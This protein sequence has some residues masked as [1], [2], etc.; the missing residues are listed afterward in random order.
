M[1]SNQIKVKQNGP[2]WTTKRTLV[3]LLLEFKLITCQYEKLY[4]HIRASKL[5]YKLNYYRNRGRY[6]FPPIK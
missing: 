6:T 1:I 4:T 5:S 2:D 3:V